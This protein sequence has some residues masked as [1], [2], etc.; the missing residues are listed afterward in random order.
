M[1]LNATSDNLGFKSFQGGIPIDP[2]SMSCL[3]QQHAFGNY[4]S[5]STLTPRRLQDHFKIASNA[6]VISSFS[7][8]LLVAYSIHLSLLSS[9]S[10]LGLALLL[11]YA[12]SIFCMNSTELST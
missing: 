7:L 12:S 11:S 1:G 2:P 3:R 10:F 5:A 4:I 8:H 6:P 9:L